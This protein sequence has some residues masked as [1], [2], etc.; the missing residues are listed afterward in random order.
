MEFLQD[1]T[2]T[3]SGGERIIYHQH[4]MLDNIELQ[5]LGSTPFLIK[6]LRL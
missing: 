1:M 3:L 6:I 2:K 5:N 4:K